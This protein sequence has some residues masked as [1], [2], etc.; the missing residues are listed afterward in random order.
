MANENENLPGV[1]VT[2]EDGNLYSGNQSLQAN[3][4]SILFIGTA[5]DGPSGEPVSV[6][7]LGIKAADKL[8]GGLIDRKTKRPVQASLLRGLYEAI[9]A[10]NEDVRLLRIGGKQAKTILQAKDVARNMEQYLGDARGNEPFF[11]DVDV[12]SGGKFVGVSKVEV[13]QKDGTAVNM[14]IGNVL[15]YID[16]ATGAEKAFFFGNKMRPGTTVRLSFD[17]ET[18]N[19]TM[20]PKL[21]G[22][23]PNYNDPDYTLS[24]DTANN[25]HF[26][27]ARNNW[28]DRLE[29]GHIPVVVVKDNATS[30][31]F[32]ISSTTPTGDYIY[33][34]GKGQT[35]NPLTDAWSDQDY[36]D[37]GI[38]FTSA[39]DNE[40]GKGTYPAL[41]G[42]VTVTV[43]YAWF[44]SFAQSSTSEGPI[45]GT[46]ATYDL[47]YAPMAT[48][49]G[50]FYKSGNTRV[51]LSEG[52]DYGV[53]I[54]DKTVTVTAG[55]APVGAQL[56]ASYKTSA[57]TVQ[58]P[59]VEVFGK[60]AGSVY[61]GLT[62]IYDLE[63]LHGVA[64]EVTTDPEDPTGYE[65]IISFYKPEEKRLSY[66]DTVL[67]YRTKKLAQI[68]TIRQFVN[69]VNNDS[70]NNVVYLAAANEYGS[71]PIQGLEV[72][73]KTFLGEQAPGTLKEDLNE[74]MDSPNRYP[75]LGSDGV[76]D[77]TSPTQ[78]QELY[79]TLGGKYDFVGDDYKL[80]QLGVYGKL[81]NYV[82]DEIVL[83]DV[84]ANTLID[85]LVPEKSFANQLA[86][87][88]ATA[89]A[90]TWET[91]GTIGVAPALSASLL[92]VQE[93]IDMLTKP[94][95]LD[96]DI[97]ADKRALY[98]RNGI[99]T[100]YVNEHYVYT[101][102]TH[103]YVLND[104]GD[105]IDIGRYVN[106][107]FGPEI[108]L[109]S[110]KIGN[111][112]TSGA[113]T[114]AALI[115][116]LNPEVSTTNRT[117]EVVKGLRYKL[118]DAQH[119]QLSDGRF[120]TFA[121][122]INQANIV[123]Y[124][125]K[126]GVT[127]ALPFSDYTRLSTVRIVHTAVQLVRRKANPFIGLP[128]GLAQRNALS[129]EIQAGLDKMKE[130]GV[131]QRFKFTIFSSV[132]DKVLGN[133]FITLELVPQFE[134]RRFNTSVVLRAA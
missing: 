54:A 119:N 22:G 130:L 44:T 1:K 80:I 101:E 122:Q 51:E 133:A 71:V 98:E 63:T 61:G 52:T 88:C 34:V 104:E 39:Y 19:Y 16:P 24:K 126:D 113:A 110:D 121:D 56:I 92:D 109:S 90:K 18:R 6:R 35:A 96:G 105:R 53:S 100:D 64:V 85:P 117:L 89:T 131:L 25:H 107:V 75:W 127:A 13:I 82:V 4:Q 62:D 129:A 125:V 106:I 17:Y 55:A 26:Y 42:D 46:A 111:Y 43:E 33:R 99:R 134:V 3:T 69:Y 8:F 23:V 65:K 103:E 70:Q 5:V 21:E 11:I 59:K 12:P 14:T 73:G 60:Y 48:G 118:S 78:M 37:G 31:V 49:F 132:Q 40:V 9:K 38:F 74:P 124:V 102:A 68:K 91:I 67:V 120:V 108:G 93:Y 114:Y 116:T 41:T 112:V 47:N 115:S 50:V 10:G 97:N 84:H 15:D 66:R 58:D 28:S 86:L 45:P 79:E 87:H 7:D 77:V 128:N 57:S 123:K 20:V 36:K 72:T 27:S 76:F 2:Y 29:S 81:E 83:L 95:F 30:E 94:G 32:T